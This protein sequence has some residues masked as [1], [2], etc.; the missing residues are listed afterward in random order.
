MKNYK[1]EEITKESYSPW[2]LRYIM[3]IALLV[4]TVSLMDRYVVA[5][6][7][8]Q[9]K[10]DLSLSDTQLGLLVGPAF[11][12]THVLS[13]LPLA[14]LAD[15]TIRRNLIIGAMSLWSIFTIVAG[16]AKS[17][18]QLLVA[19]MG[20]GVT[21]AA[22]APA[23]ASMLSDY[24]TAEKRARAM[25][26]LTLGGVAGTGAGMLLGGYVGEAYGWRAALIVA[27]IPGLV[28]TVIIWFTIREPRR[29]GS[30]NHRYVPPKTQASTLEVVRTL[31]QKR[32]F[33]WLVVGASLSYIVA[34]GRG[35]WE[36]MFLIR[37]YE[38]KQSTA[39]LAYFLIGPVPSMLGGFAGAMLVDKLAVR[40]PRWYLWMAGLTTALTAPMMIAF[41][42]WPVD[43]TLFWGQLPVGFL[44]SILGSVVGAVAHP[45]TIAV[46]QNLSS[47]SM[48]A[49]THA[50]WSVSASLIGMGLGPVIT[51]SLSEHYSEDYGNDSLRYALTIV[52]LIAIPATIAYYMGSKHIRED[53]SKI[54]E[55]AQ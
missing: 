3:V 19:R 23:L 34:I 14:R 40:D 12:V 20:V 31:A 35:A 17:F 46:A 48:R 8:D 39:G 53:F 6:L 10:V 47:P 55:H 27:G 44:F 33:V 37:V 26:M 45:A 36:P 29:G 15:R 1:Q 32:T 21:E 41:F 49:M 4:M 52:S 28:L 30:E 11:V 18:P 54:N 16:F 13:Q 2:Y 7:L 9:I 50:V 43:N 22:C 5:I 25:S 24:F 51:G 38:M 42:L